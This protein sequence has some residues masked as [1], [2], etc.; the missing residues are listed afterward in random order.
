MGSEVSFEAMLRSW[1]DLTAFTDL[2]LVS[3]ALYEKLI[4]PNKC[5]NPRW[6]LRISWSKAECMSMLNTY[7]NAGVTH[8]STAAGCGRETLNKVEVHSIDPTLTLRDRRSFPS[9]TR[10]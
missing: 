6:E 4:C 9:V 7:M 2:V 1:L 3:V 8:R 10:R 5:Q